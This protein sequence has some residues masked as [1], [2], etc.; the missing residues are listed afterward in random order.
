[1]HSRRMHTACTLTIVPACVGVG[2]WWV[3]DLSFRGDVVL[4]GGGKCCPGGGGSCPG[5]VV[6]PVQ[7]EVVDL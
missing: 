7:G 3:N 4:S 1:M 6:G 2:G 5:G